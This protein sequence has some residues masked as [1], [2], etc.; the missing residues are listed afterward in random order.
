M[1]IFDT[2]LPKIRHVLTLWRKKSF[3]AYGHS[4][5]ES[6]WKSTRDLA[7]HVIGWIE[8]TDPAVVNRRENRQSPDHRRPFE[9]VLV[10]DSDPRWSRRDELKSVC[11]NV[12][13]ANFQHISVR[14]EDDFAADRDGAPPFHVDS[15]RHICRQSMLKNFFFYCVIDHDCHFLGG[16]K[17]E[18]GTNDGN[19][20]K[21]MISVC[22]CASTVVRAWYINKLR[23]HVIP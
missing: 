5:R 14:A 13:D 20:P 22:L 10:W 19:P 3:S 4:R 7:K 23:N 8:Y 2:E 17:N 1:V 16:G 21:S 6:F 15:G 12:I 11:V 18:F 9:I